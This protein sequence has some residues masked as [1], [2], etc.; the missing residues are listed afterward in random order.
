M[1]KKSCGHT[2]KIQVV[3]KSWNE[4][5]DMEKLQLQK[6]GEYFEDLNTKCMETG[7]KHRKLPFLWS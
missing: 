4:C 5:I 1:M 6:L 2:W 7:H 3:R